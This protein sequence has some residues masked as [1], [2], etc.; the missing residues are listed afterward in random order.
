ML[1]LQP[2]LPRFT[3]YAFDGYLL[4]KFTSLSHDNDTLF[5]RSCAETYQCLCT[6]AQM[7][8]DKMCI[9]R[10]LHCLIGRVI[11]SSRM[12]PLSLYPENQV[13]II[14]LPVCMK[15]FEWILSMQRHCAQFSTNDEANIRMQPCDREEPFNYLV[16]QGPED[17]SVG[18][19]STFP[20]RDG[21]GDVAHWKKK[22]NDNNLFILQ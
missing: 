11:V 18:K 14:F 15:P 21:K 17:T 2:P 20:W 5:K 3:F 22:K 8:T 13:I 6:W 16:I 19:S 12:D 4:C 9:N 10:I 1:R 7:E